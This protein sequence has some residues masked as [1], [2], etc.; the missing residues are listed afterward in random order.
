[1]GDQ[2]G[3]YIGKGIAWLGFWLMIGLV[4]FGEGFS[5]KPTFNMLLDLIKN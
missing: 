1:M 3:K 4:N 5:L 2:A